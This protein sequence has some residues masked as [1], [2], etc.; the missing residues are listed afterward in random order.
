MYLRRL[1]GIKEWIDA[2]DPGATVILFSGALE[3]RLA[4]M[5]EDN[6]AKEAFLKE[7]NTQR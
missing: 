4:D 3:L 7:R 1:L 5:G 6:E 2:N